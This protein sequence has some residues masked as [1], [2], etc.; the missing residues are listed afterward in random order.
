MVEKYFVIEMR[1]D[2][3]LVMLLHLQKWQTATNPMF[4]L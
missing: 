3:M 2:Y 1:P 4:T